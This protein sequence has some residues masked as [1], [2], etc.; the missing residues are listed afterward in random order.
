[1]FCCRIYAVNI[2]IYVYIYAVNSLAVAAARPFYLSSA[3]LMVT[4]HMLARKRRAARQ[5]CYVLN[6]CS[7]VTA[8]AE[9]LSAV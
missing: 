2:Y 5:Q 3:A 1:M 4:V 7:F 9:L 8:H 6:L